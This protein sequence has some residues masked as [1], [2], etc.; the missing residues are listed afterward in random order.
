M[1]EAPSVFERHKLLR[2]YEESLASIFVHSEGSL[3]SVHT[4]TDAPPYANIW[5]EQTF[6][7]CPVE[8]L[9]DLEPLT[10]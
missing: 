5:T 8:L 3:S 4:A 1:L 2:R 6:V 10:R 7:Q 9:I